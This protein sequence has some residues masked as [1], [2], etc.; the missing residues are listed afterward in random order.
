MSNAS[1]IVRVRDEERTL[2]RTLASLRGQTVR[3]EIIVVDSGS[4]DG[5]IAIARRNCDRLVEIPPDE[6]SY[7]RALNLGARAASAPIHFALSAHCFAE[8]EDWIERSLRHY[9]REQVAATNGSQTFPDGIPVS[10]PFVQDAAHA[11]ANPRWGFSNHASSWRGS[12]W[13]RFPFDEQ[14][15][16][17]EDKEWALRVL[18]AGWVIVFDPALW[19]DMSHAWRSTFDY[20]RR[21]RRAA[22]AVATFSALPPY[23][24]GDL[25]R[26]WWEEIPAD[27]HSALF[28]R[29]NYRRT[30]GLLG[31]YLGYAATRRR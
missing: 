30:A 15:Y 26:E 29:L 14:L 23:R 25:L 20:Y 13:E 27:G 16:Y 8:R 22:S 28:H 11:R 19:V 2:S 1:V 7:G 6:F 17:A 24:A 3:P 21:Q 4:R 31:K 10:E 12:V 18:E 5:S 9:E